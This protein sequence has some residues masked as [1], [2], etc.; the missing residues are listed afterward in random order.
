[1]NSHLSNTELPYHHLRM[2]TAFIATN[3]PLFLL[4]QQ[5]NL[6]PDARGRA[7]L[8]YHPKTKALLLFDGYNNHLDS[9]QNSVWK[10]DGKNWELRFKQIL[11][12]VQ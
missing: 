2:V 9:T 10:W 4:A 5:N 1:M 7:H 11:R 3:S 12:K 8:I 6:L